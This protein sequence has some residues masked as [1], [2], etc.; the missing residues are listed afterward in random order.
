MR[1][2]GDKKKKQYEANLRQGAV[3]SGLNQQ[4]QKQKKKAENGFKPIDPT[5]TSPP[6]ERRV[7]FWSMFLKNWHVTITY[8]F[9]FWSFGMCV[10]FLGPTLGDLGCQTE[11]P[12]ATMS[13]VFFAQ[14]LFTLLGSIV[15]GV[16][17]QRT[18]A[19]GAMLVSL[20]ML[21]VTLAMVPQC[22]SLSMLALNLA[23]MGLFM[24]IIDTVANLCM[25][26]LYGS[27]VAPFLQALHFFYALGAFASPMINEPFL[28]KNPHHCFALIDDILQARGNS[29]ENEAAL[30]EIL[31]H[32]KIQYGFE[33]MALLQIPVAILVITV[34]LRKRK[35]S[36]SETYEIDESG[37]LT[38]HHVP[39]EG[40]IDDHN[41]ASTRQVALVTICAIVL[42]FMYDGLQGAYG[43]Y[44]YSYARKMVSDLTATEG[45][46]L[47]SCFW[48]TFAVGRLV[49]IGVATKLSPAF[50]IMFNIV[51]C[52]MAALLMLIWQH[53]RLVVYAGTCLF[54]LSLSSIYPTTI[55]L[56]ETYIDVSSV[57]TSLIVVGAAAGEMV[58]PV[59]VGHEFESVGPV[60]FQINVILVVLISII[61]VFVLFVVGASIKNQAG[62]FRLFRCCM[63]SGSDPGED[64]GLMSQHVTY[65]SRMPHEVS[66]SELHFNPNGK[67]S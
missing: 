27:N 29:T 41:A 58:Q 31:Q 20:L 16:L 44:I 54:G 35:G 12:F 46:Y 36:S 8:C 21:A 37:G 65:Y 55:S 17:V 49:S 3:E 64:T 66:S 53:S 1:L 11:T 62:L 19:H 48:G 14:A 25:I 60:M 32:S 56:A 7:Q 15:G 67:G 52:G 30:L 6:A 10:A 2:L 13:W 42:C 5:P 9:V 18:S 38:V 28:L 50:M 26:Q 47:T 57:I 39:S 24:G 51:G 33:I 4:G 45:A 34:L 59:V 43:G 22:W 40:V 61:V 63:G 23:A